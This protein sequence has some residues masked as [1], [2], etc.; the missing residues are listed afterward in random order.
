MSTINSTVQNGKWRC[1][2][3]SPIKMLLLQFYRSLLGST[4]SS[5]LCNAFK[6][7]LQWY[8][9]R[10]TV[11]PSRRNIF[12]KHKSKQ[13]TRWLMQTTEPRALCHQYIWEARAALWITWPDSKVQVGH[14]YRCCA[15]TCEY[16]SPFIL[17]MNICH[18]IKTPTLAATGGQVW[19]FEMKG[20]CRDV[21]AR[22]DGSASR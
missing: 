20:G 14:S 3:C 21:Q 16:N 17:K 7:V 18:V 13:K 11:Q 22:R 2:V 1:T 4:T 10:I 12:L 8:S 5:L 15:S 9:K 6:Q 19:Q